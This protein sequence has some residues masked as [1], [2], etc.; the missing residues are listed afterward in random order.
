LKNVLP[1]RKSSIDAILADTFMRSD[2]SERIKGYY[3]S[4]MLTAL[5]GVMV[6]TFRAHQLAPGG[7]MDRDRSLMFSEIN[8]FS[9]ID[10]VV[11]VLVRLAPVL[12][13]GIVAGILFGPS[14]LFSISFAGGF[15]A[16]LLT[17]PLMLMWDT[18]VSSSWVNK[19]EL[20]FA[21]YAAYI[22]SFF[23]VARCGAILGIWLRSIVG[24]ARL[25]E[26]AQEKIDTGIRMTWREVVVNIMGAG[27][28][29]IL[30]YA[31]NVTLPLSA[32]NR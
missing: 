12:I 5:R 24:L 21:F 6:S 18:L 9:Y 26:S 28:I 27:V 22:V 3:L 1:I 10:Y 20:F 32:P 16:F 4:R 17:W 31:W 14:E 11:S 2:L 25:P 23:L 30:V 15:A 8:K 19:K 29:N 13:F 7:K